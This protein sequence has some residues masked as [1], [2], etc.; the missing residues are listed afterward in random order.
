MVNKF[1]EDKNK[2]KGGKYEK[3]MRFVYDLKAS[4][5]FVLNKSL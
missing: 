5:C 4:R 2:E 3:K 1:C